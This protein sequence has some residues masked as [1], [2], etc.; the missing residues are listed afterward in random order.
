MLTAPFVLRM[1][2][3]SKA[4]LLTPTVDTRLQAL[5]NYTKWM[6]AL[7]KEESVTEFWNEETHV[8]RVKAAVERMKAEKEKVVEKEK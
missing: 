3:Y 6:E 2:A 8:S 7:V 4:G 5:P 1:H